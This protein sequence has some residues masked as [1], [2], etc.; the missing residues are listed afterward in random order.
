MCGLAG[1]L[2]TSRTATG[3]ELAFAVEVMVNSLRHRGPD[4]AG[5]WVKDDEGIALGHSRLSIIDL[6]DAGHQP[7]ESGRGRY[8]MVFNGEIYNHVDL[9]E[10][11]IRLGYTFKG[12]S[13]TEV[14]VNAFECWGVEDALSRFVGMFAVALWDR[15]MGQ[16][17][18]IRDRFGEKPLYYGW[19]DR[20]M[21]FASELKAIRRYPGFSG[22]ISHK[23]VALYFQ[24]GYIP[25]PYTIYEGIYKL[26]PGTLMTLCPDRLGEGFSPVPDTTNPGPRTYWKAD[27]HR[28]APGDDGRKTSIDDS[29]A[30]IHSLLEDSVGRQVMA[31]VPVGAFLSGGVDSSLVTALMVKRSKGEAI[32]TFSVG[33]AEEAYNE[34]PQ[35]RRVANHLGTVH[36]ELTVTKRDA[37]SV[38]DKLASIYDE[39]FSDSSQIPTCMLSEYARSEVVVCLS[40]DGGDEIFGGYDRYQWAG[41]IWM[42]LEHVPRSLRKLLSEILAVSPP[43]LMS[44]IS[45]VVSRGGGDARFLSN[46]RAKLHRLAHLVRARDFLGFYRLFVSVWEDVD[47]LLIGGSSMRSID[48]DWE[49]WMDLQDDAG[50][51]EKMMLYDTKS[52]LPD[53]ILVKVDRASMA[54]GLETRMPLLD[55]RLYEYVRGLPM[56]VHPGTRERKGLIKEILCRYVP[57][58]L[59]HRPKRGFAVPIGHWLRSDLYGWAERLLEKERLERQGIIDANRVQEIWKQHL[60]GKVDWQHKLWSLL[61]FQSWAEQN[62][63]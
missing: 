58:E 18:L 62:G 9:R 22:R 24:Y 35:A 55:H 49:A 44:A 14:M 3:D 1:I 15:S 19:S 37:I 60:S 61:M 38:I 43:W 50:I 45:R 12:R 6:S 23:A 33:F 34:A 59:V 8:K 52:Y 7:M 11:L 16:L 20:S 4:D 5:I 36:H 26:P 30:H 39:P 25:T 32:H 2:D 31:D 48:R 54:V 17:V 63:V 10:E 46:H 42:K 51:I 27:I 47:S 13:D 28:P 29:L 57:R 40:G 41:S 53:D 56:S 21:L